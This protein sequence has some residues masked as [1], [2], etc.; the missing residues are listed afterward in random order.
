MNSSAIAKINGSQSQ[1]LGSSYSYQS[2]VLFLITNQVFTLSGSGHLQLELNG[3]Y[4]TPGTVQGLFRLG[5]MLDVSAGLRK[6]LWNRKA[7]VALVVN[8]IFRGTYITAKTD[9][10][11]QKSFVNGNYDQQGVR[12]AFTYKFGRQT[13]EKNKNRDTGDSDEK[14]RIKQ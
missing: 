2:A 9:Y 1:F 6:Q 4:M 14:N 8:D 11:G 3:T 13:I 10:Q 5:S 12:I 7:S